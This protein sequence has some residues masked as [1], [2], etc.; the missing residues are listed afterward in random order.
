MKADTL[1]GKVA[2]VTGGARG[3]GRAYAEALVGEGAAVVIADMLEAEAKRRQ[4]PSA[5]LAVARCFNASMCLTRC[6]RKRWS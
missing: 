4:Q 2:I 1:T 3:I 6:R 5:P